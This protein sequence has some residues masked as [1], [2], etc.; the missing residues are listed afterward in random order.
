[1]NLLVAIIALIV[2]VSADD[3]L[4]GTATAAFQIEG[5]NATDGR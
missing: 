5:Y 4:W 2:T 3:F 1:M